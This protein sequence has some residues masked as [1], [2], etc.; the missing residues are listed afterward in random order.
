M[1]SVRRKAREQAL[2]ML[3][4]LEITGESDYRATMHRYWENFGEPP[5]AREFAN[6]LALGVI[7]HR[8]DI[9]ARISAC[10][11]NWK[12]SRMSYVD[13]NI[14]RLA[15]FELLHCEDIPPKVTINEAIEIG[16]RFGDRESGAFINGILDQIYRG[17]ALAGT[18]GETDPP[19]PDH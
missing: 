8:R 5:E 12:L 6:R 17:L 3:Y 2:Q 10:S 18:A 4:M 14:L 11:H 15:V 19:A 1:S 7:A 16:K 9:D 13:R